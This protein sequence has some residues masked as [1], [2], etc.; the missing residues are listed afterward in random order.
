MKKTLVLAAAVLVL[1]ACEQRAA[2]EDPMV[3]SAPAAT[4]TA[5]TMMTD[6]MSDTMSMDTTMADSMPRDSAHQM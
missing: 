4:M 5:D 3:D 2:D 1:A 6:T